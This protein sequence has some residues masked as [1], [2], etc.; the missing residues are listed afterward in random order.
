MEYMMA[1]EMREAKR[2][3]QRDRR[4]RQRER[5]QSRKDR[6]KERRSDKR[7]NRTMKLIAD[8]FGTA[9]NTFAPR[10]PDEMDIAAVSKMLES[11]KSSLCSSSSSGSSETLSS[12]NSNDSPPYK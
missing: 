8:L 4:D 11:D 10:K 1:S 12:I 3:R 7:H 2:E 5:K 9:I 6:A